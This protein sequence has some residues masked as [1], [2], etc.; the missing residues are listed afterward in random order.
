MSSMRKALPITGLLFSLLTPALCHGQKFEEDAFF[1]PLPVVLTA[2][3]LPQLL[4]DAPGSIT[5]IDRDTIE[6]SNYRNVSRLL[7]AVPGLNIGYERSHASWVSYHGI[8]VSTPGVMQV[9][10]NGATV[11]V[12]VNFGALSWT[13]MPIFMSELEQ[14]EVLRGASASTYGSTSLLGSANLITRSIGDTPTTHVRTHLGD[15]ALRDIEIGWSGR[16][17]NTGTRL[18][19][20][21]QHDEGFRG[22]ADD[23]STQRLSLVTETRIDAHNSL[24]L[25]LGSTA[26]RAERGYP[27]SPFGS[28]K[29]RESRD[30][31]A[32]FHLRWLN[33]EDTDREW[34]LGFYRQY[35][36]LEDSWRTSYGVFNDIH[37]SRD[38]R[39]GTSRFELQRRDRLARS[40]RIAWGASTQRAE[41]VSPS[42]FARNDS[43]VARQ[44]KVFA[45]AEW[46]ASDMVTVNTGL[47]TEDA[48]EGWR[49]SPRLYANFKATGDTTWRIGASRVYRAPEVFEKD[50]DF[51]IY[52]GA[53]PGL[54]IAHPFVPNPA[55]RETR[56]DTL[57]AGV[58][59]RFDTAGTTLDLRLFR[60]RLQDQIVRVP[61]P[62]PSLLAS[63]I[64][65]TQFQN[66]AST[67]TLT[68]L[69]LQLGTHP[70]TGGEFQLAWSVVERDAGSEAASS[71]IAPYVANLIWKQRWPAHWSSYLSINRVG[72]VA[73]GDSYLANGRVVVEDHTTFDVSLTRA[74]T[75]F[76]RPATASLTA[77]NLGGR[78]QEI[79]DPAMQLVYG[80]RAANRVSRQVYAGLT[81]QF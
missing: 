28:N 57:E 36:N 74:F 70:W 31:H 53:F 2:S 68:G 79:A 75:A 37:L 16:I 42:Q 4:A 63:Q 72:P 10:V 50:S 80:N 22:L 46:Q 29:V 77:L 17:G 73:S 25:R 6:A 23:R 19:V 40:L 32:L 43:L 81:L 58:L 21:E 35:V 65:T 34:S 67:T 59:T 54:L 15:N 33:A 39:G 14:I 9:L 71:G 12:P 13:T 18:I 38:R 30:R 48:G 55:L 44:N 66:A 7:R 45:N 1:E 61:V 47:T 26:E 60:E 20:G 52:D 24:H 8:G 69:E 3:R 78:H 56:A 5:V 62:S 41:T 76:G 11:E 51:R 49:V 27:D 64:Q